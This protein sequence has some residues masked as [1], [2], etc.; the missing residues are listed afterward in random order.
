MQHILLRHKFMG[1]FYKLKS[2]FF[3]PNYDKVV[4]NLSNRISQL[5]IDKQKADTELECRKNKVIKIPNFEIKHIVANKIEFKEFIT[6]PSRPVTTMDKLMQKRIEKEKERKKLLHQQVTAIFDKVR[7]FINAEQP[8]NASNN[9]FCITSFLEELEDRELNLQ[10]AELL[11]EISEL[12]T[13]LREKEI[14]RLEAEAKRRAEE[15]ERKR[16]RERL[17]KQREEEE[18][19]KKER[20][21][22][23]YEAKLAREEEMRRNEI[24][25]L[26]SLVT[27]TKPDS[28]LILQYLKMKGIKRFY[29]FTDKQ[30]LIKI[31]QFGG[32]YSWFYCE[33]NG[34]DIPNPGG[35]FDSRRLD[36][37][38]GLEDYVRLSFCDNHPMAW[39]KH[40]EGS[41]LVLLYIDIDVAGFK[42]T[43]FTDR[44]AASSSF[45]CGG[46]YNDLLKVN[47]PATQ[48]NYVSRSEGEIFYQH[49]AECMI[50]TF[51][52]LKYI[53]NIDAPVKMIF[54]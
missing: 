32:L 42:D 15:E 51:I 41:S 12:R 26:T 49:Q 53:T 19:L 4:S 18:R 7:A 16:E 52:P 10:Y 47:I 38:H 21:A 45:T 5:K 2:I 48:R 25:R 33:Q 35:D 29:H 28:K 11:G 6:H 31:K 9:L 14:K 24:S 36:R 54:S 50:K 46:E 13:T 30:N 3:R 20:E 22:R 39:R 43:L 17:R 23:E 44:N 40:K 8:D 27:I 34:I 1:L 37:W